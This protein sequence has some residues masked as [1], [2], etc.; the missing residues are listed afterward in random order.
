[1]LAFHMSDSSCPIA[2][3]TRCY[4]HWHLESKNVL[5]ILT[6]AVGTAQATDVSNIIFS[7]IL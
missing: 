1:M 5:L 3:R 6:S 2:I 4:S 7:G